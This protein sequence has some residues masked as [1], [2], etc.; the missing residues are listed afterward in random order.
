ML[1]F[2]EWFTD[3]PHRPVVLIMAFFV[4]F[5]FVLFMSCNRRSEELKQLSNLLVG[6]SKSKRRHCLDDLPA[7]LCDVLRC[8]LVMLSE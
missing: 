7:A 2:A 6:D 1:C 4:F 3:N 5:V 8:A